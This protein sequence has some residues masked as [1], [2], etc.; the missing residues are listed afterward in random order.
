MQD[1]K[2]N[3]FRRLV[4]HIFAVSIIFLI[5]A[6]IRYP[7]FQNGD[8][9]FTSDEGM[10]GSTILSLMNGERLDLLLLMVER[11]PMKLGIA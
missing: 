10:L 6:L 9:F 7:Y 4:N 5:L 8:H 1:S 11:L 2:L 3:Q